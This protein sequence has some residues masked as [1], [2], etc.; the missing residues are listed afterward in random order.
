[1]AN[2]YIDKLMEHAVSEDLRLR[3]TKLGLKLR[4]VAREAGIDAA[5]LCKYEKGAL[6][7]SPIMFNRITGAIER[8][9]RGKHANC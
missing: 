2:T 1:M 5:N 7:P 3:R 4:A 8:L 6:H 9:G